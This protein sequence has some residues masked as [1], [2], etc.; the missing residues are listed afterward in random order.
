MNYC[1]MCDSTDAVHIK[2]FKYVTMETDF[3]KSN[4][5]FCPIKRVTSRSV[6]FENTSEIISS[7][8]VCFHCCIMNAVVFIPYENVK[9]SFFA[10]KNEYNKK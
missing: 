6:W 5:I 2:H 1:T 9:T 7:F 10:Q 3:I 8:L 4:C